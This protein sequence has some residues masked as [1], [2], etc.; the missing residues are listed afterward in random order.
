MKKSLKISDTQA[1]KTSKPNTNTVIDENHPS[2]QAIKTSKPNTNT[3]IDENHPNNCICIRFA[4]LYSLYTWMVLINNCIWVS[5]IFG[6]IYE[7]IVKN[8]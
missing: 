3:V 4:C 2:I 7:K 6:Y 8:L 1:I 5:N